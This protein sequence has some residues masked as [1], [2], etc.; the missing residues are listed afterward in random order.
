MS[1]YSLNPDMSIEV[2]VRFI[3]KGSDAPLTGDAY[4]VRLF[5]KDIIGSDHLGDSGL[6]SNGT[7]I[8]KFSHSAF[9]QWKDLEKYPDLYFTLEKDGKQIF[10]SGV[11]DDFDATTIEQFKMGE[12]EV[13][14]L[15]SFLVEA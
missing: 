15:G 13:V 9:G 10:R 11:L 7:A 2:K 1:Q 4:K 3:A 6:D 12:G 5:D 14:D 8:I